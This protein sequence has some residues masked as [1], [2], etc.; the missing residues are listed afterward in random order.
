LIRPV[1]YLVHEVSKPN[2]SP[3][4]HT[5]KLVATKYYGARVTEL[6]GAQE[7]LNVFGRQFAKSWVI[8]FNSPEKADF[9]GFEGEFNEK[10]QSPKYSVS[11]IRNHRNRTT[12]YVTGTVV[13]P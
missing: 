9:V 4:D 12:M 5:K 6:N 11:Q 13:K 3:L 10:T 1:I 8:R 2:S 7:Q